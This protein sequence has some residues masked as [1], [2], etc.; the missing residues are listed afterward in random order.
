MSYR[1]DTNRNADLTEHIVYCDLIKK[2]WIVCTPS[3]RDATYDLLVDLGGDFKRVQVKKLKQCPSEWANRPGGVLKKVVKRHSQK[4]TENG[5]RRTTVDY[6]ANGIEWLA[7]VDIKTGEIFYYS[8][9]NYSQIPHNSFS[10]NKWKSDE[11]PTNINVKKNTDAP[12]W[13]CD[14]WR[15][16]EQNEK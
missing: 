12:T 3:S 5:K 1:T 7:G 9:D 13:R 10:V 6:A 15:S 4:V 2:G 14:Q 8:I 11:F 16:V